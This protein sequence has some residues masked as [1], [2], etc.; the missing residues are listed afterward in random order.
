M[1]KYSVSIRRNE[2]SSPVWKPETVRPRSIEVFNLKSDKK[3]EKIEENITKMFN[4]TTN[5]TWIAFQLFIFLHIYLFIEWM[6]SYENIPLC[7]TSVIFLLCTTSTTKILVV[8]P[9]KGMRW[10]SCYKHGH[11]H[12]IELVNKKR[13]TKKISWIRCISIFG[14]FNW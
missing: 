6:K 8:I 3:W 7:K 13:T 12:D 10:P 1:R 2:P 11:F 5:I 14:I 9:S 4:L